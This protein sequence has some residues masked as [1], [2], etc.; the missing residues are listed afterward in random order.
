MTTTPTPRTT[1]GRVAIVTGAS[2]GLGRALALRLAGEGW[3]VVVDARGERDLRAVAEAAPPGRVTAIA[4]DV[5]DAAHRRRLVRAA[6]AL[7]RLDIVVAN[8]SALGPSPLPRLADHP[9]AELE[10]VYAVNVIAPL[11]LVQLTLPALEASA[12]TIIAV[13]S[14][15]AVEAYPG[16][17][18]YGSS[19]AALDH[20]VA[21]LAR[22]HPGLRVYAV[23]PGEMDTRMLREALP[24]EDVGDRPPPESV[25]PALMRLIGRDLPSGRHRAADIAATVAA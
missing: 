18:G 2:R 25:V 7:G 21:V 24:G 11:A 20:A 15:A 23:D 19:K 3:R 5:A 9:L 6:T 12:G 4:G 1:P 14:D 16:W 22:E 13:S 17:G 10:R 8:A